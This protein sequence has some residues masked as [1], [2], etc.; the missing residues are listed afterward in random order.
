MTRRGRDM[1]LIAGSFALGALT[2][3]LAFVMMVMWFGR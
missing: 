3:L 1:V 2:M